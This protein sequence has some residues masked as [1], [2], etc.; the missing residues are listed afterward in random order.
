MPPRGET[1]VN[2]GQAGVGINTGEK[3]V[4]PPPPPPQV[5]DSSTLGKSSKKAR[6]RKFRSDRRP[7]R[8]G[9]GP[10]EQGFAGVGTGIPPCKLCNNRHPG[11]CWWTLG[12][13]LSCGAKDH[14]N[15]D[16]TR[17]VGES[18]GRGRGRV[19]FQRPAEG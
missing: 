9:R 1:R 11:D 3:R 8:F 14:K 6:D 16:Y 15:H 4:P 19:H 17:F 5:V 10:R 12:A 13:C 18:S 7:R 2:V